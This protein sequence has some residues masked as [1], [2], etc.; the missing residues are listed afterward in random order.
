MSLIKNI[1]SL[2][3]R[4]RTYIHLKDVLKFNPKQNVLYIKHLWVARDKNGRLHAF[5]L[6]PTRNC[7]WGIWKVTIVCKDFGCI[8]LPDYYLPDLEWEDEPVK[9]KFT[10]EIDD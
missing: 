7:V 4:E 2:F 8:L 6:F 1:K 10:I 5:N 9:V 3:N